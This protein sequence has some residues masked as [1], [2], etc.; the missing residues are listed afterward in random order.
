MSTTDGARGSRA[1]D[2]T[3]P[4]VKRNNRRE[5]LRHWQAPLEL[6]PPVAP[7]P[8][9]TS[10]IVGTGFVGRVCMSCRNETFVTV[11]PVPPHREGIRCA[12]CGRHNGWLPKDKS[13]A[14]RRRTAAMGIMEGTAA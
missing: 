3:R 6:P 2:V 11:P 4:E 13:E 1:H 7:E 12:V 9:F 10:A 5:A 14:L 8:S